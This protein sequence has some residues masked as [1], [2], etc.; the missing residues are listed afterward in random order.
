MLHWPHWQRG[1]LWTMS[2]YDG[3]FWTCLSQ[4]GDLHQCKTSYFGIFL[5]AWFLVQHHKLWLWIWKWQNCVNALVCPTNQFCQRNPALECPLG[6]Q[7]WS[8]HLSAD[9]QGVLFRVCMKKLHFL[10]YTDP[11]E[12]ILHHWKGLERCWVC[13]NS[14]KET[15]IIFIF[16]RWSLALSHFQFPFADSLVA[17]VSPLQFEDTEGRGK[18]L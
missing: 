4:N 12:V 1:V 14:W 5:S 2:H 18:S 8:W 9:L 7:D 11:Q 13:Q 15:L 17:V 6:T 10:L 3:P 16:S